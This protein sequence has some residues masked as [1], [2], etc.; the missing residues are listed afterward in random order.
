M[1]LIGG[2]KAKRNHC[3][4]K[5]IMIFMLFILNLVYSQNSE[6][7]DLTELQNLGTDDILKNFR[8][9]DYPKD[10]KGSQK[11]CRVPAIKLYKVQPG[12]FQQTATATP[13]KCTLGFY[14]PED[15]FQ[16]FYCCA[17][18]FCENPTTIKLCNE[19]QYCPMG[20]IRGENCWSLA[21]CPPGT[22][23]PFRY[24]M[25]IAIF[26]SLIIVAIGFSIK[27]RL[28]IQKSIRNRMLVELAKQQKANTGA[29]VFSTN[30]KSLDIEFDQLEFKL[31]DG[32]VIMKDVSGFFKMGK[33][34]AIMGPSGAG[35]ST[36]FSLLTGKIPK[37]KGTIL[38]NGKKQDLSKYKKLV[39]F[40][41]QD[42]VMHRELTVNN[43]LLHSARMRLPSSL[44]TK[45][46]KKKVVETIEFL[47]LGHVINTV[48]GDEETRGISGGQR[49]RVNIGMEIV[50]DP[51][52]LFLDEP[53]SG[54][55]SST[56][57]E[58]CEILSRLARQNNMTIAAVVHSPSPQTFSMFDDVLFLGKGGR[59]V[60]FGPT[61]GVKH[62]FKE[63]GFRC[64]KDVNPA[65]FAMDVIS[66]RIDCEFDEDFRPADLFDYWNS[67]QDGTP[68]HKI[69]GSKN[70]MRRA[71]KDTSFFP[72][73]VSSIFGLIIDAV[74]WVLDLFSELVETLVDFVRLLT[75]MSDPVRN[76][77]NVF[78]QYYLL[79]KRSFQQQFRSSKTFIFDSVIHF[80]AGL[81]VSLAIKEFPYYGRQPKEVCLLTPFLL[82]GQCNS[83]TD[84][85]NQAGMLAAVGIFFAGQATAAYTFGNEKT[86]F[87]RDTSVGMPTIPYFLAKFTSDL[88][89]IFIASFFYTLS[90]TVFFDYRT[91]FIY[92]ML[93]NLCL[94]LVAFQFGYV[95]SIF[96][97]KSSVGLLTAANAL[98]W[99]FLFGGASPDL[100]LV[101]ETPEYDN[102]RF[103]WTISAPRWAIEAF[104]ILEATDRPWIELQ[105]SEWSHTY[106]RNNYA[107][108]IIYMFIIAG[109]WAVIAVLALKLTNRRKQK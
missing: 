53:T 38:L 76:T 1:L 37:S 31:P 59:M 5:D 46:I 80:V 65:D 14:C 30:Q 105:T 4:S 6:I 12:Y 86:V 21:S 50:A 44:S 34:T 78:T 60:F 33:V 94:Y 81:I 45:Q 108:C 2:I 68:L 104:Y 99:S 97:D 102:F 100:K 23:R 16:P 39:G 95:L 19:G 74:T 92:L 107:K 87:W 89:R 54:L 58:L 51:S 98:L 63:L 7:P 32:N 93:N 52:V 106:N 18:F 72:K 35:K 29:R 84:L 57:L 61:K 40:V 101:M 71:L 96:F 73:V 75:F 82:Q 13:T 26:V 15:T 49:K 91:K 11:Y 109:L 64:P 20:A 55:D 77:P 41:P 22:E 103:I 24:G 85:L 69:G 42:D 90:L 43:I 83:G 88:P 66:G 62:Y 28:D 8:N 67:Y 79:V 9:H 25:L 47:G 27:N 36:L 70:T 10:H 56:S 3:E 48:I 17:G